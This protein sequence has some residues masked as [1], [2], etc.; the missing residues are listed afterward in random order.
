MRWV[1]RNWK[2]IVAVAAFAAWAV[3]TPLI[4][5]AVSSLIPGFEKVLKGFWR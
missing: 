4:F 5:K 2:W 1:K 3:A